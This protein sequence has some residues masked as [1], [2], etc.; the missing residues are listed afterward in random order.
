MKN[1][2]IFKKEYADKLKKLR[3][4]GKFVKNWETDPTNRKSPEAML[5]HSNRQTTFRGFI[6]ESFIWEYTPE[7]NK[8]W[9]N[10]SNK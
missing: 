6:I 10:I 8:F 9:S 5:A 7:K 4:Y 2:P 3:V 1:Q